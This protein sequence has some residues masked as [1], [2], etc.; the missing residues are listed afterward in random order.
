MEEYFNN[1][2]ETPQEPPKSEYTCRPESAGAPQ[3]KKG[4]RAAG[5]IALALCFSLLGSALGAGGVLLADHLRN[6]G[7][8]QKGSGSSGGSNVSTIYEGSRENTVIN[9]ESIDTSRVLTA[10]EVYAAYVN[11]TV[12]ITTS[13]TTNYWGYQSTS[14]ASGSGFI[15][16]ADG[17]ILTNYHVIENASSITVSLYSGE[18]YDA[19][20][21]GYDA[22]NDIAVLKVEEKDLTPVVLGDSDKLNVGDSVVAIGNPLGELTFSLTAGTIS[23]KDRAV[24]VSG[25]LTMNLL[26]TD[27]AINSGNSG[28]ALF[29]MYGEVIGVTNAK[30]SG[31]SGSGASIDNIGFAIPINSVRSIVESII[32]KGYISKPYIGVSVSDVSAEYRKFG[33]PEG[34]AVQA[35]S[36]GSPAKEAGLQVGDIITVVNGTKITGSGDL[37]TMVSAA[38]VGDKLAM[39]VY[40]QGKT[41]ELTVT[42]GEQIQSALQTGES[43][44][45]SSQGINPWGSGGFGR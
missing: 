22:S 17:Y 20:L 39:T 33:L 12:G 3:P 32:E 42:V 16:S 8:D 25:G 21:I 15:I 1:P 24:T 10:A 7:G 11:S 31:S 35:V 14:A 38:G 30:Y 26:Q 6:D 45:Q 43:S 40:R 5:L 2:Y 13:I 23:A 4:R 18:S 34:A 29:N 37:K 36:E 44:S 9:V 19:A 41:L 27:C 28:G